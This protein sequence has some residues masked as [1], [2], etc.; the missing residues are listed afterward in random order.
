MKIN[1]SLIGFGIFALAGLLVG[2]TQPFQL[3]QQGH[4]VLMMIF[5]TIGL[6]IFK[7]LAISYS[8]GGALFIA[9]MLIIGISPAAV[10]SGFVGSAVWILIPALFFGFVLTKTGLGKRIAYFGLKKTRLTYPGL[11]FTLG[12]RRHRLIHADAFHNGKSR[13]HHPDR[14]VLR[15]Y[16]EPAGRL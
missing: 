1:L 10:F 5:I 8:I 4:L 7:P 13:A 15:Q 9:S 3:D 2:L 16:F 6:W 14:A 11:L 12:A